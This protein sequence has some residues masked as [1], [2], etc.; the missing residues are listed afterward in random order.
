MATT[1]KMTNQA[2]ADK[3]IQQK[4]DM[5]ALEAELEATQLE[6]KTQGEGVYTGTKGTVT[7]SLTAGRKTTSWSDVQKLVIIPDDVLAKCT[8]IGQPSYRMTIGPL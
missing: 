4:K 5:A 6:L 8:K 3:Y 2:L 7:V 1:P